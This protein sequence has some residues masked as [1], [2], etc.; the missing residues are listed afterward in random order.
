[1]S[2]GRPRPP[3]STWIARVKQAISGE[4]QNQEQLLHTLRHAQSHHILDA[5]C[6]SIIEG[7]MQVAEMQVR[8]IMVPRAQMVAIKS[9]ATP[10]EFLPIVIESTH[11]RFPVIGENPND[12]IGILLAKDLL[13]LALNNSEKFDIKDVL[14]PV[15]FVPESKRLNVL[16]KEFRANRNHM[17]VVID[18][19]G[20]VSG[21]ATIEDVLEQIVGEIEDEHDIDEESYIRPA[22][23]DDPS[24]IVKAITPIDEFNEYFGSVFDDEEFDTI[25]GLVVQSFGHLPRRDEITTIGQ[26]Q[27]KVLNADNRRV[28]LLQVTPIAST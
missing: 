5:D 11:S 20:S 19:Y 16:L 10:K 18:E 2:E 13:P 24:C 4:P 25:G 8:E 28:H 9:T 17:A 7:A 22:G 21:I 14:R 23:D 27:F 26:F 6:L 15:T 12:I 1:M 3:Q